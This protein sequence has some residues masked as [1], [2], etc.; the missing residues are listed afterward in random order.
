MQN[1]MTTTDA[2]K[3]TTYWQ[4]VQDHLAA[5]MPTVPLLS[6]KPPAAAA[7]YVKG[8]VPVG[9]LTELFNSVWLDK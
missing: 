7:K 4:E 3:A 2:A 9:N 8:F 5:D 6:S 1:A